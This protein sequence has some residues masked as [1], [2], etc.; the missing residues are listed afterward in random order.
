MTINDLANVQLPA[1]TNERTDDLF[2]RAQHCAGTL[3][4]GK[5][6]YKRPYLVEKS[7]ELIA[8]SNELVRRGIITGIPE[9]ILILVSP[10]L[11]ER[12]LEPRP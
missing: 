1:I 11:T 3:G 12:D 7:R 6:W 9:E 2:A 4:D 8:I 10:Y 5:D